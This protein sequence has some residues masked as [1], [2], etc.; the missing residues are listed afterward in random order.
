MKLTTIFSFAFALMTT[1]AAPALAAPNPFRNLGPQITSAT[2]QGSAFTTDP[3]GRDIVLT[4]MRGKPAKMLMFDARTGQFI[5][6]MP[7][8]GAEGAWN[9]CTASDGS[10]YAG[11]D[12][13]GH[14]YRYVPGEDSVRDLGQVAEGQTFAFDVAPG[15]DGEV[16]IGTYPGC[17]VLRYHPD[18]G[19]RDVGKGAV[20]PGENYARTV[21]YNPS[22]GKVYVGI[23]AHA[24]L[25]EL[26]PKTG[27]KRDLLPAK[28][29][30]QT[31]AYNVDFT[32]GRVFCSIT[33]ANEL[34]VLDPATGELKASVKDIPA[35]QP[36]SPPMPGGGKSVYFRA[37]SD[38]VRLDLE[39]NTTEPVFG[40]S[41]NFVLG[42]TWM[43]FDGADFPGHTLVAMTRHKRLLRHNPQTGKT[44]YVDLTDVPSE[45][46]PI[47]SIFRGPDG[48][49]YTGGYL[50]GGVGAYDPKADK[51]EQLGGLSQSEDM[52]SIGNTIYFGVYPKARLNKHELG[53]K[54]DAR[55]GNPRE[56]AV[57]HE[58]GQDRP[59]AMLGVEE[60]G[61][62][63][64]LFVGTVPGYGLLG[65]A[66]T[67]YDVKSEKL[68][69]HRN[70]VPDQAVVSLVRDKATNLIVG[71][72]SISGGLGI[73]PKAQEAV[74]FG[75]DDA[76]GAK[77]FEVAPV[78]GAHIISALMTGPDGHVWGV[79]DGTLFVFDV[80]KREVVSRHELLPVKYEA[81]QHAW[82]G[83]F[84]ETAPDGTIYGTLRGKL[85]RLDPKTK[86]M[87]VLLD[88]GAEQ[89][90]IDDAGRV[91]YKDG[92]D[93][94]Q[95]TPA[96]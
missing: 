54:W 6:S 20:A 89:V 26:D 12:A 39:S 47:Q 69:V 67:V 16:F 91:Y 14:V 15:A 73:G 53:K 17:L 3:S 51:S 5:R 86:Q 30:D 71:G 62:A 45:P 32:G 90:A 44:D 36:I 87:T 42:F 2:V 95:Y 64:K 35:Q 79:A 94:W 92:V 60:L 83:A 31:F 18:D 49:I 75:W 25:I 19:F 34:I 81:D 80:A 61:E 93:L 11:A 85:F 78:S 66:L 72:T 50:T 8:E 59:V 28:Y 77:V 10:V 29:K 57:L 38:L 46:T 48:R 43:Q 65:G 13:N 1:L 33:D 76:T 27:E 68:D 24:R 40:L 7:M 22:N 70:V 56:F 9:A 55:R 63:G 23:G 84:L 96:K 74:L 58:H 88:R 4:V 52:T 37:G 21:A 82:R 41:A